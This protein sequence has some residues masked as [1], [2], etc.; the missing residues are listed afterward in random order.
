MSLLLDALNRA[1]K[2]KAAAAAASLTGPSPIEGPTS[3][4]P[5]P[6]AEQAAG[7]APRPDA[8]SPSLPPLE[9][10]LSS[11]ARS[12][13]APVAPVATQPDVWHTEP[14]QVTPERALMA[15]FVLSESH[16]VTTTSGSS[17]EPVTPPSGLPA[18]AAPVSRSQPVAPDAPRVAQEL[19]RAKAPASRPKPPLRP[20]IL[21]S[22]AA[23]LAL[24]LGSVLLG[25]WG[26]PTS[27][28]Q[29]GGLA[30]PAITAPTGVPVTAPLVVA[31]AVATEATTTA[32]TATTG[33]TPASAAGLAQPAAGRPPV[34]KPLVAASRSTKPPVHSVAPDVE[35]GAVPGP[36]QS[37]RPP[38]AAS[39]VPPG[40]PGQAG[41]SSRTAGPSTLEQAYAALLQGRLPA[42][43]QAYAQV[44]QVNREERDAL[45]GLAY[46]AHR[47]GQLDEARIYYQRVLRQEPGNPI[48]GAGLLALS[49]A[50]DPHSVASRSRDVAEQHPDSAAAQSALGHAMVREGRL[51]DAQQAFSRAQA[52]EPAVA[53][54]AF[55]LAVAL[56]R[57]RNFGAARHYYE[58]ALALSSQ[59]GGEQASGVPQAVVQ[60]RLEQ[61]RAAQVANPLG[62]ARE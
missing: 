13:V 51:A 40:V 59:S 52:L 50:D 11:V 55:N 8:A 44:L 62:A 57:L 53:Q 16:P 25:W 21:G 48:A 10:S 36:A 41:V 31:P 18:T 35:P 29:S 27:W 34:S 15:P 12:P 5:S 60:A 7:A 6:L 30:G 3:A 46:I 39:K 58:R 22:L 24:G 2:D 32:T 33:M 42:A 14:A 20:L 4:E 28:L 56:D 38:Q 43:A 1:S 26:D 49:T 61:L 9:L 23:F 54:H 17:P 37:P 47:Q 19:Q 45:L